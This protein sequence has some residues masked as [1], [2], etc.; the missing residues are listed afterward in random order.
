V[1]DAKCK[2][3]F[4]VRTAP[5]DATTRAARWGFKLRT[6]ET[7]ALT[8]R[9]RYPKHILLLLQYRDKSSKVIQDSVMITR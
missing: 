1:F 6:L 2:T 3:P 5:R 4:R 9:L 7:D 8:Q